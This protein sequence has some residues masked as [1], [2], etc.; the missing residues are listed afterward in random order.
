MLVFINVR[1]GVSLLNRTRETLRY[2]NNNIM[3]DHSNVSIM[4][5][6]VRVHARVCYCGCQSVFPGFPRPFSDPGGRVG[7]CGWASDFLDL[8]PSNDRIGI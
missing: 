5:V 1:V 6:C 3:T 8:Q 2:K 4:I 7:S